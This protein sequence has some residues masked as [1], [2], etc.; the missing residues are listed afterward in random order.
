MTNTSKDNPAISKFS[1]RNFPRRWRGRFRLWRDQIGRKFR[2]DPAKGGPKGDSARA[3][4]VPIWLFIPLFVLLVVLLIKYF[5]L[6]TSF[7]VSV[8]IKSPLT[9]E[10]FTKGE[11]LYKKQC[12]VCHGSQG[13]A[14]GKAA[15]LLYPKPR[16]FIRDKFRLVSTINM[17]AT[18][19]DLF[20]T[21]SRGMPGSGMPP[22]EYLN[23]EDRW[24]LVYYVRY[25][26]ELGKYQQEGQIS[27]EM[28]KS[29]L[30][31]EW[32]EKIVRKEI[33]EEQM[34]K[35]PAEPPVTKEELDK[36][37][38]VFMASCA[39][40]HGAAGKG[41]GSQKMQDSL[42]YSLRP[43]D[44]TA[45]IY[46]GSSS[47]EDLYYRMVSGIPGSPMPSYTG[48]LTEE[49]IW[50]LIH[51]TQSL[52]KPG[53]EEM[54]RLKHLK[55]TAKRTSGDILLDFSSSLWTKAE[56]V[57]VA[58]TPLWWRDDRIEGV[59]VKVVHNGKKIAFYLS[60]E[61]LYPDEEGVAVQ[62]FTDGA[63][64]QFSPEKDP[65]FFGMGDELAPVYIWHW[66][67]VW[68]RQGEARTDIETTYPNT[69]VDWYPSQKNYQPGSSFEVSQAKTQF[70]DPQFITG[71]GAGN[72]LSD[73]QREGSAE[74]AQAK[75][76]GS[77]TYQSPKTEKV[78]A[79]GFWKDGKWHVVFIRP[80]KSS[81]SENL[82]FNPREP[83][84]VAFALWDGARKDRDGQKMVSI[85]NEL[86][87][88]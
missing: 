50:Q 70:H 10:I 24:A 65:P 62:S 82:Q 72:P 16:D 46:K 75:G 6:V 76:L 29:G 23:S 26:S 56:S 42:G 28:I 83:L 2:C 12:A 77:Y 63:A 39:G 18:D 73:P 59:D 19:E 69:A 34:V 32:I 45:G 74:E 52:T 53:A 14:D 81:E 54:S 37:R 64:L 80:L 86:T 47:S 17:E 49:Q 61:D 43:R 66:K 35:V 20:K 60:W 87:L 68:E 36:G 27:E 1:H 57:F 3:K 78:E 22:W 11:A 33:S 41:D 8:H 5:P 79:K 31:W 38:E 58:L 67:A 85:W 9:Q 84:S 40:C 44:L 4:R 21:I 15:Y 48:T 7:K 51:Y 30:S 88:E 55:L 71:W 13:A 25:L